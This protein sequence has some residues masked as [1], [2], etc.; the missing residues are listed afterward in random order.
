MVASGATRRVGLGVGS[1]DPNHWATA[2]RTSIDP[3][4]HRLF[5][6]AIKFVFLATKGIFAMFVY[7]MG[8]L[9]GAFA[10]NPPDAVVVYG[11]AGLGLMVMASGFVI[12]GLIASD[13][14]LLEAMK[15]AITRA[16]E[17]DGVTSEE[18]LNVVAWNAGFQRFSLRIVVG[19][20]LI[21]ALG[22]AG[23]ATAL[24]GGDVM[25]SYAMIGLSA[26]AHLVF[27]AAGFPAL[28]ARALREA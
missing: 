18:E 2:S 11:I 3:A 20:M 8:T 13:S 12:P 1:N 9:E 17:E 14:A 26:V 21:E 4:R 28:A 23:L 7:I 27:P 10:D 22:M 19:F 5:P 6:T 16:R 24:I 25:V 15:A